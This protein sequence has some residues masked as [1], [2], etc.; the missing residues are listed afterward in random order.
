MTTTLF[1]RRHLFNSAGRGLT[2]IAL[3][4]LLA[5]D[6][7]GDEHIASNTQ[8]SKP[9]D[10]TAK[11]TLSAPRSKSV[12]Q[13]FMH[14]GP[15]QVDL[16]DPKPALDK[17]DGQK[18]PGVI[19]VQQPEQAGGILKSPFKFTKHGQSGIDVSDIMPHLARHVDDICV[20]R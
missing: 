6:A 5:R 20:I 3:L 18:F 9:L 11:A 17:Y 13:L 10:L 7:F 12:I 19:D 16:L 1:N 8:A 15:S 14:G 2:G 4:E